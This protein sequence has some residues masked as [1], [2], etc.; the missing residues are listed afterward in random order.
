MKFQNLSSYRQLIFDFHPTP[1]YLFNNFVVCEENEIAYKASLT[2]SQS[3]LEGINPIFICGESGTGKTHLLNAIGNSIRQ[4]FHPLNLLY[5][6]SSDI[7]ERYNNTLSYEEIIDISREYKKVD[8]LMIDDI[9]LINNIEIV[10]EQVF[11][12]YNE[13]VSKGKRI[14]VA[15]RI[16]P[17]QMTGLN[18]YLKSRLLSGMIAAI[19]SNHGTIKKSILKKMALDENLIISDASA[20]YILNHFSRDI[21]ELGKIIKKINKYSISGKR[22]VTPELIREAM[23]S[24]E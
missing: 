19:K 12:I 18:D 17:D 14:I 1:K 23:K 7:L 8:I 11:H 21:E 4:S 13:L 16:S 2:V 6:S 24:H 3:P 15:G 22:K 9:H 10:Q 20:D 5:V